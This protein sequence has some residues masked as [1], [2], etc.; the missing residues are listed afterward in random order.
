MHSVIQLH[1]GAGSLQA[2]PQA[3]NTKGKS[4]MIDVDGKRYVIG[5]RIPL[6]RCSHDGN[7]WRENG[8]LSF[9]GKT[10]LPLIG[11]IGRWGREHTAR[12]GKLMEVKSKGK[13]EEGSS[14]AVTSCKETK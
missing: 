10:L 7:E 2:N 8:S 6:C 14:R 5:E 3:G 13:S 12:F 9:Y 11:T 4:F 1:C